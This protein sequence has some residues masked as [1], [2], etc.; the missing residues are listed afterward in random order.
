MVVAVEEEEEE[1]GLAAL[2]AIARAPWEILGES[3]EEVD[4]VDGL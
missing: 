2:V 1:D 3:E 4:E